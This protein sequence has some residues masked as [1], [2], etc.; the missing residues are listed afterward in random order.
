MSQS[1]IS[2]EPLL[3]LKGAL[4]CEKLVRQGMKVC[5]TEY[6]CTRLQGVCVKKADI[7]KDFK[8][9]GI[10]RKKKSVNQCCFAKVTDFDV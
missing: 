1:L 6:K 4:L 9:T 2:C 10:N 7:S 5:H 8:I 3:R